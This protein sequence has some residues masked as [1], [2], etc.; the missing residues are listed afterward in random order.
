ME[1]QPVGRA[2]RFSLSAAPALQNEWPSERT[3][4]RRTEKLGD[5][6]GSVPQLYST[7]AKTSPGF[8]AA[9]GIADIFFTTPFFGDLIS[10]CIFMASTTTMP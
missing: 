2:V 8:T 7:M 6:R 9:P 10:F 5:E 4:K 3:R 1:F